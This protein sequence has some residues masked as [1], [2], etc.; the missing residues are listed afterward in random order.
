MIAFKR[1]ISIFYCI[2]LRK[3]KKLSLLPNLKVNYCAVIV[4]L[5]FLKESISY[6]L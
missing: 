6:H 1:L 3:K 2:P 5:T 4:Q